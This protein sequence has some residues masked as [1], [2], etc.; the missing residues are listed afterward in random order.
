MRHF[1]ETSTLEM[2]LAG[3]VGGFAIML[4]RLLVIAG[5]VIAGKVLRTLVRWLERP[6]ESCSRS[7]YS[8]LFA[9]VSVILSPFYEP[10][11]VLVGRGRVIPKDGRMCKTI[12]AVCTQTSEMET[13]LPTSLMDN[14]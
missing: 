4:V 12:L 14:A 11:H 3:R 1:V 9:D 13:V 5:M 8:D 6:L 7:M 2:L 10:R